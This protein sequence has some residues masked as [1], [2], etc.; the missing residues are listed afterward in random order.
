MKLLFFFF[1]IF[2]SNEICKFSMVCE[3][4][5]DENVCLKKTKTEADNIFHIELSPLKAQNEKY[6][7]VYD[8][9]LNLYEEDIKEEQLLSLIPKF[10]GGKCENDFEC[11]FGICIEGKCMNSLNNINCETNE[12][13]PLN[14]SCINNTCLKLKSLKQSCNFSTECEFNLYCDQ[15]NK[16]CNKLFSFKDGTN[17]TGH[18]FENERPEFLCESGGY[19]INNEKQYICVTLINVNNLCY[20]DCEYIRNDTKEI[21]H[22]PDKC[23]CGFN[24]YRSKHCVLGNGADVF[25]EYLKMKKQILSNSNY[26]SLCHTTERYSDDICVELKSKRSVLW[27]QDFQKYNNL[28]I[29]ALEHHRI[30]N[31]DDCIKNVVFNYNTLPVIPDS[32][33]CPIVKCDEKINECAYGKNP[34][35]ENGDN[36]TLLFNEKICKKDEKCIIYSNDEKFFM[37]Y[38]FKNEEISGYCTKKMGDGETES[39][40]RYPGEECDEKKNQCLYNKECKNKKC[41]GYKKNETCQDFEECEVG[42]F[43]NKT[44]GVCEIQKNEG[45]YCQDSWECKNYLGCYKNSCIKY[46]SLKANMRNTIN[47]S[48]FSGDEE[49][50]YYLCEFGKLDKTQTFCVTTD[51]DSYWIWT[52]NKTLTDGFIECQNGELCYYVE[53]KRNFSLKCECGFNEEGK[54]YCPIPININKHEWKKRMNL[55]S[56]L[57]N[58]KCHTLNRFKCYSYDNYDIYEQY[59]LISAKTTHAHLLY[60][61]SKCIKNM[62]GG[63]LF[64]KVNWVFFLVLALII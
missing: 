41:V 4:N 24:K 23:L 7:N 54:G 26:T 14:Q 16:T 12:N 9:L 51:Y 59:H 21:I 49:K 50:R 39:S 18:F 44:S 15:K 63:N 33:S 27:R 25:K 61:S 1:P 3:N 64:L 36:I 17:I 38:I 30:Q 11:L 31:S 42:L 13:C 60:N 2:I 10:P 52:H 56:E 22:L 57:T 47:E 55:L 43:C 48:L 6:C 8:S 20:D 35:N 5:L 62:Y 19:Y 53:G 46:G 34:F 32:M 58:N 29:L 28:K 40:L 45:E 37:N